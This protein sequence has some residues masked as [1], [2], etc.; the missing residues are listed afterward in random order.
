MA[1]VTLTYYLDVLSSWCLIAED[2]LAKVRADFEGQID[3]AWCIAALRHPLHYTP[4][5]LTF[6]YR[7]THSVTGV[8]LNPVWL[9]SPA[10]G[11]WLA[12]V[13]AEAARGLGCTDDTVRLALA[14]GAMVDGKHMSQRDVVV[15][16]AARAGGLDPRA[17]SQ[18]MDDPRTAERIA[19]SSAEFAKLN[20]N[21]RPTFVVSN[22]I[23]DISVLSGCWRHDLLASAI[24]AHVEDQ[25]IYD[26]FMADNRAPAGV[27]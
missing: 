21:V 16:T 23:G 18:A 11:T 13:A 15:E 1:K 20:V 7:R 22:A 9:E 3:Y 4:E 24:K 8:M 12:D 17:L 2:A 5:Q 26:K 19:G 27:V 6:Y 10:D 14:R 25:R